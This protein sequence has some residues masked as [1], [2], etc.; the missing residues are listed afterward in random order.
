MWVLCCREIQ[1]SLVA[2]SK[3][4]PIDANPKSTTGDTHLVLILFALEVRS[5]KRLVKEMVGEN[6][7][8]EALLVDDDGS[9]R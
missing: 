2:I 7:A 5:A 4:C 3:A 8:L 9:F 1:I 6:R